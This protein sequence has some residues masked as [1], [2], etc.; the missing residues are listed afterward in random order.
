MEKTKEYKW[1]L[2]YYNSL[3]D[4]PPECSLFSPEIMHRDF[5]KCN[6]TN[7]D[8]YEYP[9]FETL[10]YDEGCHEKEVNHFLKITDP[11]YVVFYTRH[12]KQNKIVG[13]FK[14]GEKDTFKYGKE[15]KQG[16]YASESVLLPKDRCIPI[17]YRSRGVPVSWGN[18]KIKDFVSNELKKL[19]NNRTDNITTKYKQETKSIMEKLTIASGRKEIINNCNQCLVKSS[20]HWGN[21]GRKFM[22]EMLNDL[23]KHKFTC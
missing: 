5:F 11:K 1:I 22:V 8:H 7:T 18:S 19:I 6:P 10:S 9:K 12:N 17:D 21:Q 4:M 20:C 14:V 2:F 13:Y 15:Y 3:P 16:F 23:Y